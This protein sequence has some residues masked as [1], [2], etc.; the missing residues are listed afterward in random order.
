MSRLAC[1]RPRPDVRRPA[2][3]GGA[4]GAPHHGAVGGDLPESYGPPAVLRATVASRTDYDAAPGRHPRLEPR[5]PLD[6]PPSQLA[7]LALVAECRPCGRSSR[8]TLPTAARCSS[9]DRLAGAAVEPTRRPSTSW[10]ST[11]GTSG[12]CGRGPP[13]PLGATA[14]GTWWRCGG[15]SAGRRRATGGWWCS[16]RAWGDELARAAGQTD[17]APAAPTITVPGAVRRR[18]I[19]GPLVLRRCPHVVLAGGPNVLVSPADET[20]SRRATAPTRRTL[21]S[22]SSG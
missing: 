2:R 4:A 11:R 5:S 12:A 15:R 18:S 10:P 7:D 9:R 19:A 6:A 3:A 8:Q 16:P 13:R 1:E 17:R 20:P 14:A 22:A 21:P